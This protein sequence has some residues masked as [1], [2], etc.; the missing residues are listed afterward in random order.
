MIN[1]MLPSGSGNFLQTADPENV[2]IIM[3][4]QPIE[5]SMMLIKE[6][7]PDARHVGILISPSDEDSIDVLTKIAQKTGLVIHPELVVNDDEIGRKLSQLLDKI[8]VLLAQPDIKIHNRKTV[9]KILLSSY[10]KNIPVIGFSS[11]FVKAGALAAV[12]SSPEDIGQHIG[13]SIASYLRHGKITAGTSFPRFFS[14]SINK[15][16]AHSLGI[17][18]DSE[19]D[20]IAGF[21]RD[22][23][24]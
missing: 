5:R 22:N 15:Q 20:D 16:V 12:F 4:D 6:V 11:A 18:L 2:Q 17:Q 10:R 13:D 8:D 23:E 9:S 3:L 1:A 7:V 14:V 19:P 21:I 24:K